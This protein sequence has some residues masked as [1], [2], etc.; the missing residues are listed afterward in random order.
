MLLTQPE[1]GFVHVPG[2]DAM[3]QLTENITGGIAV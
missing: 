3:N 2:L 1:H